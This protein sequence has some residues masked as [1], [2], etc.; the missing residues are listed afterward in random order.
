MSI[1]LAP[2]YI[3]LC[4]NDTSWLTQAK[5]QQDASAPRSRVYSFCFAQTALH[6]PEQL[7]DGKNAKFVVRDVFREGIEGYGSTMSRAHEYAVGQCIIK[8][9]EEFKTGIARDNEMDIGARNHLYNQGYTDAEI[10]AIM[11]EYGKSEI[12]NLDCMDN[13]EFGYK[14]TLLAY[15]S[16]ALRLYETGRIKKGKPDKKNRAK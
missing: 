11:R 7:H 4:L 15:N 6:A 9:C 12:L 1:T 5:A 2:L 8:T 3:A 16:C 14:T 13:S 10:E